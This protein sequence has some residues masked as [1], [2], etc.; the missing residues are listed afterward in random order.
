MTWA[1]ETFETQRGEKPVDWFIK[2]QQT[3]AR[4][5]IAHLLDLLEQ[6]QKT[7]QKELDIAQQRIKDIQD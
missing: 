3:Q 6:T 7:P 2:K 5:K 4:T 1:I